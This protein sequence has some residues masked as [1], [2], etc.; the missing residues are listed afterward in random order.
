MGMLFIH[1]TNYI[2]LAFGELS[3]LDHPS[4]STMV[5]N[6]RECLDNRSDFDATSAYLVLGLTTIGYDI[7][8][9]K[10]IVHESPTTDW[11]QS[12]IYW[13]KYPQLVRIMV[14]S[15]LRL[16]KHHLQETNGQQRFAYSFNG[17]IEQLCTPDTFV[18]RMM[19]KAATP[20][21]VQLCDYV[22]TTLSRINDPSLAVEYIMF[23]LESFFNATDQK[24][25]WVTDPC[26]LH[27]LNRISETIFTNC[28]E[29][30]VS[31]TDLRDRI[32]ELFSRTS[33]EEEFK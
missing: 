5:K 23:W 17:I 26:C 14:D 15:S 6:V 27:A 18:G 25:S 28:T 21:L 2:R 8:E 9:F 3:S 12:M 16:L 11:L 7:I 31:S 29:L 19:A 24:S 30:L 32:M 22:C 4:M 33:I 20:Q 13:R 1:K 10:K